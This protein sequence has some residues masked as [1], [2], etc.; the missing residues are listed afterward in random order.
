MV[1]RT[2]KVARWHEA[3]AAEMEEGEVARAAKKAW[4]RQQEK[5]NNTNCPTPDT[6]V[7]PP[8]H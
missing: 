2:A 6:M 4:A 7:S 1:A 5:K 8:Q 3:L